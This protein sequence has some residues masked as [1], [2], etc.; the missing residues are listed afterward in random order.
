MVPRGN[1]FRTIQTSQGVN[2]AVSNHIFPIL[3]TG[4][5]RQPD[6]IPEDDIYVRPIRYFWTP[7]HNRTISTDDTIHYRNAFEAEPLPGT[8]PDPTWGIDSEFNIFAYNLADFAQR[9]DSDLHTIR[10]PDG[11]VVTAFLRPFRNLS[12]LSVGTPPPVAALR[13]KPVLLFDLYVWPKV[14]F[15]GDDPDNPIP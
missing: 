15:C 10:I 2:Y 3:I 8:F 7:V 9:Y 5:D 4:W 12:D 1:S 14:M 6:D 11:F 13:E